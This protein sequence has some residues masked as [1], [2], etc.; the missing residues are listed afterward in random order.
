MIRLRSFQKGDL[1]QLHE[2]DQICF[3]RGI[4]YSIAELKYFLV[5]PRCLCWIAEDAEDIELKLAGFI[6]V[7]RLRRASEMSG[8][9]I[10][11]D[12]RPEARRHGVGKLLMQAAEERL[13]S[14]GANWLTLEV[15]VDNGA[16]RA[17]YGC[18]GFYRTGRIPG[19]YPGKLD[20]EVME[21]AI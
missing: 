10:T 1:P 18:M 8:H 17:F 21:K 6:I 13:K 4:S 7:E 12:V 9:I 3:P 16:A 19:Y 2:L 14:E 20:A 11:I 15:A 5:N